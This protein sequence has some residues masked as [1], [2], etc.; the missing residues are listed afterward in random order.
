MIVFWTGSLPN[1]DQHRDHLMQYFWPRPPVTSETPKL[2]IH[3]S[4][5]HHRPPLSSSDQFLT[6]RNS[7]RRHSCGLTI[8]PGKKDIYPKPK[9]NE[10]K[11]TQ[12]FLHLKNQRATWLQ[13]CAVL[14]CGKHVSSFN[15]SLL[16][17][18]TA[19]N[20][21]VRYSRT[22][23]NSHLTLLHPCIKS[24]LFRLTLKKT[25]G[26]GQNGGFRPKRR[27]TRKEGPPS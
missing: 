15:C 12:T 11:H 18:P 14:N 16:L 3:S 26:L 10:D 22:A 27:R 9:T 2:L 19:K 6:G 21:T 24:R 7:P 17:C 1:F 8:L 4:Q 20:E 13:W 25:G 23:V 5:K